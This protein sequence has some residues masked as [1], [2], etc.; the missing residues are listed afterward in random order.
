MGLLLLIRTRAK[1]YM[2]SVLHRVIYDHMPKTLMFKFFIARGE[3]FCNTGIIR[4]D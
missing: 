1:L 4:W 2:T 3:Q